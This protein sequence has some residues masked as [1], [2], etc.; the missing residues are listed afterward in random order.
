M[1]SLAGRW[2]TGATRWKRVGTI[3]NAFW[4]SGVEARGGIE[5]P[6]R[7]FAVPGLTTWLPRRLIRLKM[8]VLSGWCKC[9]TW[10]EW[11]F[12]FGGCKDLTRGGLEDV[13]D[14]W[15]TFLQTSLESAMPK[16]WWR[17]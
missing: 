16:G 11:E 8:V 1:Q 15:N 7:G 3:E 6:N 4:V 12:G 5:P 10:V 9:E 2:G 13:F 17:F 14:G